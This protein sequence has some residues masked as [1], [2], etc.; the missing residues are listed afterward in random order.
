MNITL[1]CVGNLLSIFP[2]VPALA[3]EL[4]CRRRIRTP[5]GFQFDTEDLYYTITNKNGIKGFTYGGFRQRVVNR[6][7]ILG[8]KLEVIDYQKPLP[9]PKWN[10]L[11]KLRQ[12]QDRIIASII[13]SHRGIVSVPT[14]MGKSFLI[15][16]F[17]RIYP[18][19]KFLIVT[20]RKAVTEMLYKGVKE[21]CDGV[22]ARLFGVRQDCPG[23]AQIIVSTT[24]SMHKVSP[25]WPDVVFF[26]EAHG[27]AAPNTAALLAEYGKAKLFGL[28]AS[29]YGRSDAADILTEA[30]FGQVICNIEYQEAVTD[31]VIAD[32]E[33]HIAD[34]N[35]PEVIFGADVEAERYG[36]WM[37]ERRNQIMVNKARE[38]LLPSDQTLF[39]VKTAEHGLALRR[40]LPGVPLVHSGIG[41]EQWDW[42]CQLNLV[43]PDEYDLLAKV[44]PSKL[45]KAFETGEIPWMI[46]TTIWKEGVDF[47]NLKGLVRMDGEGGPISSTQIP[48]RLSRKGSSGEKRVGYLIDAYDNF[49]KRFLNRSRRRLREY[50]KK[51]WRIVR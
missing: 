15:T 6:L 50:R 20:P 22:A 49:G 21:K 1:E 44:K 51:G 17:C 41:R 23:N 38:L 29:P 47:L 46:A 18:D 27:A 32:I 37:N 39:F 26:D 14:A 12:N 8:H 4:V 25:D 33:V 28:T 19:L 30:F 45:Q 36:Y 34:V 35:L 48:G 13:A 16:T 24:A 31:G 3:T 40:L 11:P 9:D 42:F 2:W 7:R 10:L 43:Q 5:F